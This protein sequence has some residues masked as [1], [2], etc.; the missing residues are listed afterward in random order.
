MIKSVLTNDPRKNPAVRKT[1]VAWISWRGHRGATSRMPVRL[2]VTISPS[3]PWMW[4]KSLAWP[5]DPWMYV[6]VVPL[7]RRV[8]MPVV[9][10]RAPCD[11]VDPMCQIHPNRALPMSRKSKTIG[12]EKQSRTPLPAGRAIRKVPPKKERH[13]NSPHFLNRNP[14]K[15]PKNYRHLC[16]RRKRKSYKEECYLPLAVPKNNRN[17]TWRRMTMIRWVKTI[18]DTPWDNT[19]WTTLWM[20]RLISWISR[21]KR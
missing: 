13:P 20:S 5:P 18:L 1:R 10:Q 14:R 15:R 16:R 4:P 2:T 11:K 21:Y 12:K 17:Q 8:V 3:C 7:V 6:T 19:L 9:V